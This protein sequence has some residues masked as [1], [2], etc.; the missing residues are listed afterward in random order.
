M[1]SAWCARVKTPILAV[2]E[3]LPGA[4]PGADRLRRRRHGASAGSSWWPAVRCS[5][6]CRCMC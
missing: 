4:A 3:Q 5:R 1:S 2:T 6:D